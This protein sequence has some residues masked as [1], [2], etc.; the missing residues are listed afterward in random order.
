MA[1]PCQKS[2]ADARAAKIFPLFPK[3]C[4]RATAMSALKSFI[5]VLILMSAPLFNARGDAGDGIEFFEKTIRPL[6]VEHCYKCHSAESE[7]IKGGLMLDTRE[8]LLKGGD[9]GP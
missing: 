7:K 9:T 6:L 1:L 3:R 4:I 5:A 2:A 8:A